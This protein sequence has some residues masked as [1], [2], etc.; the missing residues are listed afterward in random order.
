VD[1]LQE[2]RKASPPSS[3]SDTENWGG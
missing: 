1:M 3:S 2:C